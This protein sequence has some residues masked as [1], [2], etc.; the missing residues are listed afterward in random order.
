MPPGTYDLAVKVTGGRRTGICRSPR[1]VHVVQQYPT[2]PV[3]VTFG[4]LDTSAQYQSEYLSRLVTVTNL[5]APDMVLCSNAV[6]PAYLSGALA[7]LDA[8]YVINF[9]NHQ[10]RGHEAWYGDP[11][12]LTDFGPHLSVLNFGHPWH[13]DLSRA[14]ALLTSRPNTAVRII[15]AFEP[16]APLEFLNRHQVRMIHDAHGPGKKVQDLGSTPTRRIGK[17][18]SESFR[19]VRF[20]NNRVSTCTYNG[21]ETAPVPFGRE[22]ASPLTVTFQQPNDGTCADNTAIVTSRLLDACP[23][24]RVT[25]V[26]PAGRYDITGGRPESQIASDDGRFHVLSVRTDIP[27]SDSVTITVRRLEE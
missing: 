2:D 15:N 23:D 9:G 7:E 10:F 22:A 12:G 19:I 25:F 11:V 18:N 27:A 14:E 24:G 6:N 21:H 26:V 1:S 20:R 8:P 13:V 4:H 3:F 5:L 17:T 16:N